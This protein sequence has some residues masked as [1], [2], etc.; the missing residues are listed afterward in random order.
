MFFTIEI[1]TGKIKEVQSIPSWATHWQF[2]PTDPTLL[3]FC[4]QGP[5]YEANERIWLIHTDGS[6]LTNVNPRKNPGELYTHEFWSPDGKTIWSNFQDTK[7]YPP[8]YLVGENIITGE[9]TTYTL[10]PEQ[11]SRHFNISHDGKFFAA[12]SAAP[13]KNHPHPM[14]MLLTQT[15]VRH[16]KKQLQRPGW[17]RQGTQCYVLSRR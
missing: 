2:S 5:S 3:E 6:S 9:R 17:Q 12:D 1:S 15:T 8:P 14:I 11:T 7:T 16:L 13:D 4:H 10:T